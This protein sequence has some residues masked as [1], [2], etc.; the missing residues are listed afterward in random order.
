MIFED[1]MCYFFFVCLADNVVEDF[2]GQQVRAENKATHP[3]YQPVTPKLSLG[4]QAANGVHA[5]LLGSVCENRGCVHERP[6][7]SCRRRP[8]EGLIICLR[9]KYSTCITW[10]GDSLGRAVYASLQRDD[11]YMP[12]SSEE[13]DLVSVGLLARAPH[14]CYKSD[15]ALPVDQLSQPSTSLILVKY[16]TVDSGNIAIAVRARKLPRRS[17]C[18]MRG[19]RKNTLHAQCSQ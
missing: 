12:T 5:H 7:L 18:Q 1:L 2:S 17:N 10:R 11:M 8:T 15:R 3:C 14:L 16:W 19:G 9:P 13:P 4:G 6:R